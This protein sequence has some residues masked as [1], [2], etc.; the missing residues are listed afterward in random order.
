MPVHLRK[1]LLHPL[2]QLEIVV[3]R[4]I[5][6]DASLKQHSG[7]AEIHRLLNFLSQLV[8]G[9]EIPLRIPRTAIERAEAALVDT[10]IGVVDVAV[11]DVGDHLRIIETPSDGVGSLA[12]LKQLSLPEQQQCFV[13]GDPLPLNRPIQ[14]FVDSFTR[15]GVLPFSHSICLSSSISPYFAASP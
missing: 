11:D 3:Q 1:L 8:A 10:D 9:Q 6:M 15:S 5:R 14:D 2:K 12:E 13:I 7:P 4:E